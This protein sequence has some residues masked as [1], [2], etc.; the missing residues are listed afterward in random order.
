VTVTQPTVPGFDN[1]SLTVRILANGEAT[2]RLEIFNTGNGPG[3]VGVTANE[4]RYSGTIVA[5]YV[6]GAVPAPLVIRFNSNSTLAAVQA[7][8]RSVTF[9]SVSDNPSTTQR[10][11]NFVLTD[12]HRGTSAGSDAYIKVQRVND[13]PIIWNLGP[14]PTFEEDEPPVYIAPAAKFTD[15]DSFNFNAGQLTVQLTQNGQASDLIAIKS[16]GNGTGQISAANGTVKYQGVVIGTYSGGN[17]TSPLVITFNGNSTILGVQALI[18][19]LQFSTAGQNP[20]GATRKVSLVMTDGDGGT[21]TPAVKDLKVLPINDAPILTASG[22][23][24][25]TLNTSAI[26]VAPAATVSDVDNPNFGG[27]NLRVHI[28]TNVDDSNRVSIGGNFTVTGLQVKLG[29]TLIGTIN[30]DGGNGQTD[31]IVTFN[32]NATVSVVQQLIR[33]IRFRTV[34]S[35]LH[36]NRAVDFTVDDGAGQTSNTA[37]RTVQIA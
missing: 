9:R 19:S 27:G 14:A 3:Q 13:A 34:N 1:G 23:V 35:T 36:G 28:S 22:S 8:V 33:A 17:G 30:V 24:G 10:R 11:V 21:S 29:S 37:I 16:T 18:E 6:G 5:T 25:Y 2:D 4:I 20:S 7:V 31:L 12:G 26:A 15:Y 32:A